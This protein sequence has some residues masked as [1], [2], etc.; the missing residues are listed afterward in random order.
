MI[1]KTFSHHVLFGLSLLLLS[2]L[3]VT[4]RAQAAPEAAPAA[5]SEVGAAG[6][7]A[8]DA[9]RQGDQ[10]LPGIRV[11]RENRLVDVAAAVV[12]R[13]GD[14]MELLGCAPESREYESILVVKAR[15]SHLHLAL[16]MI[17]L[18]PGHPLQI[19]WK[20][21]KPVAIPPAGARVAVSLVYTDADGKTHDVP[22]NKWIKNQVTGELLE[23]NVWLFAGSTLRQSED[24]SRP[25]VYLAD[26]N[27]S[28]ISLVNFG[29]DVLARDSVTT[30]RNDNGAW[31]ANTDLV[32]PVG[33]E[34]VIR[35][36]PAPP[37]PDAPPAEA[38][39]E[40]DAPATQ[41]TDKDADNDAAKAD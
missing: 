25:P 41:P 2:T 14:W 21:E 10:A 28:V 35:L 24:K 37:P 32:P 12:T 29:D 38:A 6:A 39:K 7:N 3:H 20:D 4:A 5:S 1:Y 27:G 26:V 9:P 18:E 8:A 19:Q 31:A 23:G 17:G 40:G 16:V 30:N 15:P 11:D 22:A 34:V 36:T 33:T 13:E